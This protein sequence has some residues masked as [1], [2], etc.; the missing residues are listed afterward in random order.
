MKVRATATFLAMV[1]ASTLLHAAVL[2]WSPGEAATETLIGVSRVAPVHTRVIGPT[3]PGPHPDPAPAAEQVAEAVPTPPPAETS[4]WRA[5]KAAAPAMA[6][7]ASTPA[8]QPAPETARAP[9]PPP[10]PW[11]SDDFISGVLLDR[12]P[13]PLVPIDV[14]MPPNSA[15]IV[16]HHAVLLTVLIDSTGEVLEVIT[17]AADSVP[18]EYV[19]LAR[20]SFANAKFSPG[21][22]GRQTVRSRVRVE[23]NFD[24]EP[25]P[26]GRR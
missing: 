22:V 10:S 15:P 19:E 7:P 5:S 11:R 9:A 17:E 1:A 23:F 20:K 14:Q 2:Q 3:E 12:A 8:S 21:V 6:E 13:L 16:G 18:K 25:A 24:E 4:A 26:T